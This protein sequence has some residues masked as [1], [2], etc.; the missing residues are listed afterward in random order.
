MTG[1]GLLCLAIADGTIS[2]LKRERDPKA[3][4]IDITKDV[5]VGAGMRFLGSIID[6]PVAKKLKRGL[7]AQVPQIGG[8]SY[9]FLFTLERVCVALDLETLG[10]KD[11]FNWGAEVL[12]ANQQNDGSW[13]GDHGTAD[14]CFALL[15]LR[16]ANLASDLTSRLKGKVSDETTLKATGGGDLKGIKTKAL[17]ERNDSQNPHSP[18]P[19]KPIDDKSDSGKIAKAIVQSDGARQQQLIERARDEKGIQQTEALMTAIPHLSG[20]AKTNAREAL[21]QRLARM[22]AATLT[23]YLK[24]DEPE[25]RIAA[26]Y[27]CANKDSK[28]H[29]PLL[30]EMLS[31]KDPVVARAVAEALSKWTNQKFGPQPNATAEERDKAI[32]AWQEWWKKQQK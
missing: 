7:P 15:F 2:D 23:D 13:K 32:A 11:W 28:A 29:I 3:P 26:A 31:D 5:N 19:P 12:L 10:G 1:A 24:D 6:D 8:K 9:Y 14:T 17:E 20:T 27:A 30:I 18:S 22:T 16:R 25:L 4:N 21:A